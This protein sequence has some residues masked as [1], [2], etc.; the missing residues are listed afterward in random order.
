MDEWVERLF[1]ELRQM[2]TQMATK[3]DVAR[4]NGRIERLE[5]TVAATREDVAA[6]D[7]RIGTIERTMATKEDVAELP[8]IR[9]AVV[10]TLETLNE[11]SAMK[12]T[13]TEVQQKVNETIAGQ[14]R[15]ELVLQSLALHL[16]EHESEI[17]ALK[18]R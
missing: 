14:A 10:E 17:R 9:Q 8:F 5:Q 7:E 11:I 2:R 13:L 15:Q 16:L 1:D 18:A 3:E 6:L 4:L 12:Q